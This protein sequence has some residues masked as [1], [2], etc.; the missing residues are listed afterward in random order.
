[1]HRGIVQIPT[2]SANGRN[3]GLAELAW[4]FQS[5]TIQ[6]AIAGLF[7]V[8]MGKQIIIYLRKS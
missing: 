5:Y 8:H 6:L 4:V 7:L 3:R 1:M 2:A